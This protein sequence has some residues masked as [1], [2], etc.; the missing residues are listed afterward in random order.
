MMKISQPR[1]IV[2][3]DH[4]AYLWSIHM[5]G[6]RHDIVWW[7]TDGTIRVSFQIDA[8]RTSRFVKLG[9]PYSP[10]YSLREAVAAVNDWVQAQI[11]REGIA[12]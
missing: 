7:V 10:R 4:D 8:K 2:V 9:P 11:L 3:A 1:R 6:V 12:S 5:D